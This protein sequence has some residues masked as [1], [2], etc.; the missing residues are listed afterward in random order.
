MK[1]RAPAKVEKQPSGQ[2]TRRNQSMSSDVGAVAPVQ[3]D[4]QQRG[5]PEGTAKRQPER[6]QAE[7]VGAEE[8]Q[9]KGGAKSSSPKAKPSTAKSTA[10][11]SSSA[12]V[13]K[14]DA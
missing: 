6:G 8:M 13:Q 12:K 10:S 2:K 14:T 11:A 9:Q 1:A 5:A 4:Q 7:D 3:G